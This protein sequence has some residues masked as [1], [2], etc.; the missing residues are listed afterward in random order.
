MSDVKAMV[1]A[2][3]VPLLGMES[4]EKDALA[5]I[6]AFRTQLD[7]WGFMAAEIPGIGARVQE[8]YDEFAAA[9][10]ATSP[11]LADFSAS[12]T[13][14]TDSGGNHGFFEFGSEIPRLAKGKPD[15]KEFL[16]VSGAML[17]DVPAGSGAMLTAFP[18]LADS[19]R[20][21]FRTAFA[22]ARALGDVVTEL[23]PGNPPKLSLAEYSSIL[24]A[25]HYRDSGEREVLAHEHSGIQMLGVQL[26]PSDGGLQYVLN[27]GTWVEPVIQGTDVVLINIG[28]M[29]A[30]ASGQ[31]VRPSTHR[32]HRSDMNQSAERWSSVLFVHPEHNDHQWY[33]DENAETVHSDECWADFVNQGLRDLGLGSQLGAGAAD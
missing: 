20:F 6:D 31:R 27:D 7:G 26:P 16:H 30:K 1:L 2:G 25:I 32:V 3:E 11:K 17:D 29:L 24:R 21:L 33:V 28:R 13:P 8:L 22:V 9:L 14:Q 4:I 12:V 19:S 18:G 23:L 15:P 10:A 5:N